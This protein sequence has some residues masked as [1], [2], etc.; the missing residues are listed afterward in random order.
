MTTTGTMRRAWRAP[1]ALVAL[2]M[3]PVIAGAVR[4]GQLAGGTVTPEDARFAAAPVPV[5]LHIVGATVFC[6]LGAF[7]FVPGLRGH[8]WH[9]LAGRVV[10]PCGLVAALSGLWMTL[11]Y[12][13]PPGDGELI[14]LLRLVFGT[15][16][17]VALVL[18]LIA[19]RARDFRTHRA[20]VIRGYAIGQGAGSQAVT[21]G[22]WT[23]FAGVPGE[24]TRALLIGAG[25]VINLAVAE[26]IIRER[27]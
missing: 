23:A 11:F 16:M 12:P 1:T 6:L 4:V 17:A 25:W 5:V 15:G 21:S 14:T 27:R 18:G 9:R 22:L 19:V 20:W 3:V 13:Q 26:W 10:I 8:R 2:T 7:Q 24:T